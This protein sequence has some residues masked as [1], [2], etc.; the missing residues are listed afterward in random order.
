MALESGTLAPNVVAA[1][2]A[3]VAGVVFLLFA[4]VHLRRRPTLVRGR[5]ITLAC[6]LVIL[7][8]LFIQPIHELIKGA[9]LGETD[10]WR[11]ASRL[12]LFVVVTVAVAWYFRGWLLFNVATSVLGDL[13]RGSCQASDLGCRS[14]DPRFGG[15]EKRFRLGEEELEL[16]VRREPGSRFAS[17]YVRSHKGLPWLKGFAGELGRRSADLRTGRYYSRAV[18][19]LLI[20]LVCLGFAVILFLPERLGLVVSPPTTFYR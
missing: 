11:G 8:P 13:I 9:L 18:I 15:K 4:A 2:C 6:L 16:R 7:F 19:F 1:L 12:A 14:A 5:T 20:G 17:L 10:A 3:V